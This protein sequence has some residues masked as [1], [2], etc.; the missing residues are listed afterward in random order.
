MKK[1][2]VMLTLGLFTT[3]VLTAC[4]SN[5]A[6]LL[7]DMQLVDQQQQQADAESILGVAK[8]IKNSS[9]LAFKEL[10]KNSD[11]MITP[12]EY[13]VGTPDSAKAF[14]AIDHNHDGKIVLN[15]FTPGFLSKIGL[16]FRL[17]SA[18]DGLFKLLDKSK[19][20]LVSKEELTSGLVSQAFLNEFDK[21]DVKGKS[22]FHNDAKGYLSK[23]EFEN[24]FA[25]VAVSNIK[26]T[27]G[28][29]PADPNPAPPASPAPAGN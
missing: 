17:T 6:P 1:S 19:D 4:G 27:T 5:S 18:A 3:S 2:I 12:E 13:G 9:T 29:T 22:L 28:T 25:H 8:E 14:Y 10:D 15:E 7:N 24:L 26:N 23:T 11:K 16:T 21:Y 20:K